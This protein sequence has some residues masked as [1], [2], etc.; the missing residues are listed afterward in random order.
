METLEMQ[1]WWRRRY[2][3]LVLLLFI[4]FRI[5]F[6]FERSFF[7]FLCIKNS[8]KSSY[9]CNFGDGAKFLPFLNLIFRFSL[10]SCK[11][12]WDWIQVS[13]NLRLE[14]I[15]SNLVLKFNKK[16]LKILFW[17]GCH[18]INFWFLGTA[19]LVFSFF[20]YKCTLH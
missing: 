13:W 20:I 6:G 8:H 12:I 15:Y 3:N 9:K 11:E 10:P 14:Y 16:I 4:I 7:Q 2:F 5:R 18:W 17:R 1:Y 19:S